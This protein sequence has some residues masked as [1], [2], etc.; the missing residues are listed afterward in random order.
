MINAAPTIVAVE[1]DSAWVVI[2]AVSLVL[3][4]VT[5]LLRRLINRPGGL[6]SAA[7]MGL[8]LVLPLIAAALYQGGVLPEIGV[9]TPLPDAVLNRSTGVLP[10]VLMLSDGRPGIG[11]PYAVDGSTGQIILLVGL[12]ASSLMLLRRMAGVVALRGL[13]R[14]CAPLGEAEDDWLRDLVHDLAESSGIRAPELLILPEGLSGAFATG[15]RLK[16]VLLSRDLLESLERDELKGIV[17]HEIAHIANRDISI[18]STA[19]FLRDLVA[20]N[21]LAHLSFHLLVMDRECEADRRAAAATGQPLAVASSLLKVCDMMRRNRGLKTKMALAF[22]RPRSRL[23]KRINNLLALAD[24]VA[25]PAPLG[26]LPFM[27]AAC[28]ACLL[29]LQVGAKIA[30]QAESGGLAIVLGAPDTGEVWR[31]ETAPKFFGKKDGKAGSKAKKSQWVGNVNLWPADLAVRENDFPRFL[32]SLT[33]WAKRHDL[34]PRRFVQSTTQGWRAVPLFGG[35]GY[36]SLYRIDPLGR[37]AP[38]NSE[39]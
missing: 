24:G 20:W 26:M 18:V 13:L 37:V 35:P 1:T 8:P 21:P 11:I 3:L 19:G 12:A 28:L 10:H 2:L 36:L 7:L 25:S 17:A 22:F 32:R 5:F 23:K 33:T 34:P 31:A 29:G 6:G 27:M 15:G 16:R 9:L 39:A 38:L 30:A 4:P 14:R